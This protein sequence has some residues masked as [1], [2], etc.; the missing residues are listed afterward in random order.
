MSSPASFNRN[1]LRLGLMVLPERLVEAFASARTLVDLQPPTLDQAILAAFIA[2]GPLR[3]S[4]PPY[5]PDLCGTHR[6]SKTAADK[7]LNA[8][9]YLVHAGA[10]ILTLG[11]LKTWIPT[12]SEKPARIRPDKSL[13]RWLGAN[14]NYD[15]AE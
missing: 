13:E 9:F 11:W 1:E 5:A 10:G 7:H 3:P 6:R 12:D 4:S 14:L 15:P 8:V 2:E